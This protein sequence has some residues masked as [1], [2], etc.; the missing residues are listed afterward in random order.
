MARVNILPPEIVSKIAAGEVIERPASIVKEL[1]ENSLDAGADSITLK[2]A[3][4]GKDLIHIIDNGS[5]IDEDDLENIFL[6]HSTSKIKTIDDLYS[7]SSLG[8]RG[9]ALYSVAA[10]ADVNLKS[11][12][13]NQASAWEIN[14]RG[15]K[16][17][18]HRPCTM[19][20]GT[21]II[22][23]EI[24]YNTPARKKFLKQDTT[25]LNHILS[26]FTPY[27]LLYPKR[28]FTLIHN[29]KT[30]INVR[31]DEDFKNRFAKI[32]N[33]DSKYV[34][35]QSNTLPQENLEV[36]MFLGDMNIRRSRKDMQFIFVNDRPVDYKHLGYALAQVYRNILPPG[37]HPFYCI[38][39]KV[40]AEDIDV[41]VHPTKREIKI[42]NDR[43][44]VSSIASWAKQ[45]ILANSNARE[46][47]ILNK[48]GEEL[49]RE[50]KNII[51]PVS[52]YSSGI[53][54]TNS[55]EKKIYQQATPSETSSLFENAKEFG[56]DFA[57]NAEA[58]AYD[59]PH[60]L[61]MKHKLQNAQFIGQF[62]KKYLIYESND[63]MLFMDQH[64]AHERINFERFS[65]AIAE[66]NIEVQ[67]LLCPITVPLSPQEK[68]SYEENAEFFENFGFSINYWNDNTLAIH[69]HPIIIKKPEN[70]VRNMLS[71]IKL[72]FSSHDEIA[73]KAC[74]ASIMSGD[75]L[76]REESLQLK[77]QLLKCNDPFTCP[78]GRPTIIEIT[79]STIAKHFLRG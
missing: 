21:E 29:N 20:N 42:K 36:E 62:M 46:L 8:F 26:I 71:G 30:I 57:T 15:L 43:N 5:G 38:K 10:I 77:E 68:V 59:T 78:H 24:F 67:Q 39:I 3:K 14:M 76:N 34:L 54:S 49:G 6:R 40:P 63:I 50:D 32:L 60:T 45:A 16:K 64:A 37:V 19:P 73:R 52:N 17:I 23:K 25:E 2:L 47:K 79:E 56:F 33:I 28:S 11:K 69:A 61:N 75:T 31:S 51:S 7:I 65:K 13:A 55:Q 12:P 53:Q 9:E 58:Q 66:Q 72:A 1:M 22:I 70:A 48:D 74:R 4:A 35:H 41:N 27:T 18:S 44:V